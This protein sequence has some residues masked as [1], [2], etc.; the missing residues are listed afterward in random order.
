MRSALRKT[1]VRQPAVAGLF[2]PGDAAELR[3]ITLRYLRQ[4]PAIDLPAVKAAI[5]PHAGYIYSGP[6]AAAAYALVAMQCRSIRRVVLI[7]PSHRVYLQGIAVPS[8]DTFVT[9]LGEIP[10]DGELRALLLRRGGVIESDTPHAMEHCLEVQLPFL[11]TILEE[12]TLLPLVAG[13]ASPQRVASVLDDAWGSGETLVL[14]SSDLSHYHTYEAAQRIDTGT[15]EAILRYDT[16]LSGDQA[17]GAVAINGLLHLAR[18][19]G[20]QVTQ[21]ARCNS[22]DTA[23]DRTRVVG[24]GAFAIHDIGKALVEPAGC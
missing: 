23:G 8:A 17:C 19:R 3:E 18:Q 16:G 21:I 4:A 5:V 7:G 1:S 22:G 9:P 6:V 24:Y 15:S 11:Q 14:A 20:L 13:S 12:F 2:Y 10:I